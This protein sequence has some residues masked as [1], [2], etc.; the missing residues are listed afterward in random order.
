MT[1][2]ACSCSPTAP[3]GRGRGR[4]KRHPQDG[5]G[6]GSR[7]PGVPD[8]C[9]R[10]SRDR[11]PG[12]EL[13]DP[14]RSRPGRPRRCAAI[15]PDVP[16]RAPTK[17]DPTYRQERAG[18]ETG[19]TPSDWWVIS[20]HGR[21]DGCRA[22]ARTR[23]RTTQPSDQQ[24][25]HDT[26]RDTKRVQPP[27]N[28]IVPGVVAGNHVTGRGCSQ[29]VAT[30]LQAVGRRFDPDLRLVVDASRYRWEPRQPAGFQPLARVSQC[31]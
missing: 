13:S 6:D 29:R 5:G 23:P 16:G 15:H 19:Q 4:S 11:R 1:Q 3:R 8:R 24:C 27:G 26:V 22:P 17:L 21:P 7:P 12:P 31:G 2:S 14:G 18:V 9:G 30:A 10:H 28:G 20:L 25:G